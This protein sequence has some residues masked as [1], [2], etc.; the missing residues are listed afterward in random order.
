MGKKFFCLA[1]FFL[2]ALL[3]VFCRPPAALAAEASY[4]LAVESLAVD[5]SQPAAGHSTTLTIK[6]K[7]NGASAL[8]STAGILNYAYEISDFTLTSIS[9]TE[10][11]TANP[12]APGEYVTYTLVG[13]FG[14]PGSKTVSFQVDTSNQLSE[15][16]EDN[17]SLEETVTVVAY[18]DLAFDSITVTPAAP[19]VGQECEI[20]VRAKNA[21]AASLYSYSGITDIEYQFPDFHKESQTYPVVS[22]AQRLLSGEY[23]VYVFRGYFTQA[24]EKTLTFTLDA[25][26][27]LAEGYEDNNSGEKT[28]T[29]VEAENYDLAVKSIAFDP[30]E[31]LVN[32]AVTITVTVVN[33]SQVSLTAGTGLAADD[34]KITYTNFSLENT[35]YPDW[36]TLTNPFNPQAELTYVFSGHFLGAGEKKFTFRL[37]K[38]NELTESD[39]DNNYLE[40]TTTV[41]LTAAARDDFEISQ[42]KVMPLSSAKVKISWQTSRPTTGSVVYQKKFGGE[43]AQTASASGSAAKQSVTLTGL[44]AGT[45]Y[46]YYIQAS[47][48][49]VSKYSTQAEF[50]LP[51]NND[52]YLVGAP[53][54]VVD[55]AASSA[56]ISWQTNLAGTGYVYYRRSGSSEFQSVGSDS[57]SQEHQLA[58]NNLAAGIYEFYCLSSSDFGQTATSSL[59]QFIISSTAASQEP[60]ASETGS[61]SL[62]DSSSA[63]VEAQTAKDQAL[64]QRLAGRIVLRVQ[65]AG[66]A[67]Y[68]SPQDSKYYYLGRPADAFQIMRQVGLGITNADLAKIPVGLSALTGQ[69]TDSDGLPDL[70]EQAIGTNPNLA[71]SDQDG[72]NDKDELTRGYSPEQAGTKLALDPGFAQRQAGKIFLQVEAHGEAW[73][74]NPA[75]GKRYFLGRPADAF[76]IMRQLGLGI[77]EADFARLAG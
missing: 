21:G 77:S 62:P 74:V 4:D 27:Q 63:K 33:N 76:Q 67:Y 60:A 70:F 65:A 45:T 13:V 15:T 44:S 20:Q 38:N 61:S 3:A 31:P 22:T 36:P 48:G 73:Y 9:N 53:T 50:S 57:L 1:S 18:Y 10:V 30:A 6:V 51:A 12:V 34:I 35:T 24:G 8:T 37:D 26:D 68:L 56:A 17:N 52:F 55:S 29:V 11:S 39:E 46:N 66:E 69:D 25:A 5:P 28:L 72:Y 43:A 47:Y 32:Q 71:D 23:A 75:D 16:S 54:A 40:A 19:A 41:F 58:L 64:Y 59:G 14:S 7:N 49:T 2:L 42:I